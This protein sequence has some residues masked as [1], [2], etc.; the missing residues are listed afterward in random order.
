[1]L[2]FSDVLIAALTDTLSEHPELVPA[3][4][5]GLGGGISSFPD[6]SLLLQKLFEMDSVDKNALK[7]VL[8]SPYRLQRTNKR[9]INKRNNPAESQLL[10]ST[11]LGLGKYKTP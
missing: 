3:A 6:S 8:M 10:K 5:E 9:G 1:M 4:R 7:S 11:P 2:Y